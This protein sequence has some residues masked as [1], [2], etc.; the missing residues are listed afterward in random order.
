MERL[1]AIE[2]EMT[3]KLLHCLDQRV[4]QV[5]IVA[6][7]GSDISQERFRGEA[8]RFTHCAFIKKQSG[9]WRIHHLLN[10]H[11]GPEGHLYEQAP[12]CFFRDDPWSYRTEILVPSHALQARLRL[13]LSSSLGETIYGHHYSKIAYPRSTRFQNSNQWVIELIGAAL[14]GARS[15]EHAQQFLHD[16]HLQPSTVLKPSLAGFIGQWIYAMKAPNTR[17]SDHPKSSRARGEFS[18]VSP[19]TVRHFLEE[20][21]HLA[22]R[23]EIAPEV[24]APLRATQTNTSP[25]PSS[26]LKPGGHEKAP[27][28]QRRGAQ[29]ALPGSQ[30]G[31]Q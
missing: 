29:G 31:V 5:G 16:N 14:S 10:T 11:G 23:V 27:S 28:D 4:E 21:H 22:S 2:A 12:E 18:F 26:H 19:T 7:A 24:D 8:P 6:R 30:G 20:N 15:R 1:K 13:I 9:D 17:F 3:G 25:P